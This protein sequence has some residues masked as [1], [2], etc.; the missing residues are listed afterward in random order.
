VAIILAGLIG[1]P[2]QAD[3]VTS[4]SFTTTI[5][6]DT[7]TAIPGGAGRFAMFD[8]RVA[9]M[10]TDPCVSGGNGTVTSFIPTEPCV[11]GT[12]FVVGGRGSVSQQGGRVTHIPHS[13]VHGTTHTACRRAPYFDSRLC[14]RCI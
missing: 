2:L 4:L 7:T 6:A 11:S 12:N 13:V 10:P 9:F 5:L 8:A 1:A 14:K 3:A